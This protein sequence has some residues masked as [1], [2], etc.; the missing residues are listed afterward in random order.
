M[1]RRH[2]SMLSFVLFSAIASQAFAQATPIS[3]V[4]ADGE[5]WNITMANGK[6]MKLTL[7]PDGSARM[8]IGIMSR[9][10]GWE[11]TP[12]GLCLTGMPGGGKCVALIRTETGYAGMENGKAVFVLERSR[13][14]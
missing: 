14:N 10:L 12:E 11:P 8:R 2:L 4:I 7:S 13:A 3:S 1:I 5:P 9:K 6:T